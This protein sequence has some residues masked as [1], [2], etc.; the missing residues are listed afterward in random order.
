M[1]SRA[2]A[3][4]PECRIRTGGSD[5]RSLRASAAPW[6]MLSVPR[7]RRAPRPNHQG[8]DASAVTEDERFA[9]GAP[10]VA[11]NVPSVS[12]VTKVVAIN[13]AGCRNAEGTHR[14]LDHWRRAGWAGHEPHAEPAPLPAPAGG[15]GQNRSTLAYRTV[16]WPKVSVS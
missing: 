5:A 8:Q 16:G 10:A 1:R 9:E 13:R 7:C 6:G 3:P 14:D 11:A 12:L 2:R 15:T 4:E